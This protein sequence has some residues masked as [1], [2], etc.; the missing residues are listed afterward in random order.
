MNTIQT[1]LKVVPEFSSQSEFEAFKENTDREVEAWISEL[2]TLPD[3]MGYSIGQA[4][5]V[6]G[7]RI[8]F[9]AIPTM[10]ETE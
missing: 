9:Q 4:F 2:P 6:D 8:V 10:E 3:G 7:K 1:L 5:T